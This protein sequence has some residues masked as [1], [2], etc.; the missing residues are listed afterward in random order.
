MTDVFIKEKKKFKPL[1]CGFHSHAEFSLDG[2]STSKDKIIYADSLGMAADTLT[3]HGV[4]SGLYSQWAAANKLK[5]SGK[6]SS[7]FK[8]IQGVEAYVIDHDRPMKPLRKGSD[9]MVHQYYHLTIHFK[10]MNAY[11]YFCQ[12]SRKAEERAI[13]KYGERKP[14]IEFTELEPICKE[15][16]IGSGCLSSPVQKNILQGR[17]ELARKHYEYLRSLVGPSNFYVEVFPHITDHE[18]KKPVFDKATKKIV[19]PGY[20]EPITAPRDWEGK[21]EDVWQPDPCTGCLDIQKV[22]NKAVLEFAAKYGDKPVVSLDD[23]YG[24]PKD[25]TVQELRL[26]NGTENWKFYNS[27]HVMS[28]EEAAVNFK[29]QLGASDKEIES[30][31]DNGYE[32]IEHFNN[33][34]FPDR[35]D[36]I[37][38]PTTEMVYDVRAA[39]KSSRE[40]FWELVEKHGKMP[41]EGDPRYKTYRERVEFELSVLIDN[42]AGIDF[43]P[44]V[45]LLEDL[46]EYARNNTILYTS[47]GCLTG[48]TLVK[49]EKCYKKLSDIVVGDNV[50][51]HTGE[52][53]PVTHTMSYPLYNKKLTEIKTEFAFGSVKMTPEHKVWGVKRKLKNTYKKPNGGIQRYWCDFSEK[54]LEWVAAKDL[55]VGDLIYTPFVDRKTE[56]FGEKIDLASYVKS[57]EY[58]KYQICEKYIDVKIPLNNDLSLRNIE[59]NTGVRR[60]VL[61]KLKKRQNVSTNITAFLNFLKLRNLTLEDWISN[62]NTRTVRIERFIPKNEEFWYLIGKWI[63][64]GWISDNQKSVTGYAFHSEE[65]VEIQKTKDFFEKYCIYVSFR[66]AKNRKLTQLEL[67]GI[68]LCRVLREMFPDYKN[69]S[70]TKYIGQY[71]NLKDEYL[72]ALIL[73]L[74]SADGSVC[75][76]R[77][78]IDTTSVRLAKEIKEC[79]LYLKIPSSILASEPRMSGKYLCRK[80]YKVAFCGLS[81]EYK[82]PKKMIQENGYFS[83]V[84]SINS[85]EDYDTVY[86]ITVEKNHSYL[87]SNF[88]VH[89]SAGGSL[90]LFL[91]GIIITDPI[92]HK[93]SFERFLNPGRI[94]GGSWPDVDLDWENRHLIIDYIRKKYGD[95]FALI[96]NDSKMKLKTSILDATRAV[97]GHVPN[98]IAFLSKRISIPIGEDDARWLYGDDGE[99]GFWNSDDPLAKELRAFADA[100]EE[101]WNMVNRCMGITR[102]RGIHAGGIVI[103]PKPVHECMPVIKAKDSEDY[104]TAYDMIGVEET[105]G[106]KFDILGIKTLDAL[107]VAMRSIE[108]TTGEKMV[109]GE[110]PE[111]PEVFENVIK[112]MKLEGVFQLNT[113]VAR[114]YV[115]KTQPKNIKEISALT[116]LCRPGALDAPCPDPSVNMTAA[117]YYVEVAQGRR[118]PYF[119]HEDL[120]PIL[121]ETHS[122]IL[123]QEQSMK[124]GTLAG[125]SEADADTIIRKGIGKKKKDKIEQFS[126]DLKRELPKRGWSDEQIEQLINAVMASARYQFN[127]AHSASYAIVAWNCAYIKHYYPAHYWKG[128]LTTFDGD[129][130]KLKGLLEEC[131]P[132]IRPLSIKHSHP[133]DWTIEDETFLRPPI[134]IVKGCGEKGADALRAIVDQFKPSSWDEF[135][136]A[137][138]EAKKEKTHK[139]DVAAI[140]KLLYVGALDEFITDA[141]TLKTYEEYRKDLVKSIKSTAKLTKAKKNE[142]IGLIDLKNDLHLNLWRFQSNPLHH[143][144]FVKYFENALKNMGFVLTGNKNMI[145]EKIDNGDRHQ[146]WASYEA[147][148][149]PQLQRLLRVKPKEAHFHFYFLGQTQ[150]VEHVTNKGKRRLNFQIF[151]GEDTTSRITFWPPW[152]QDDIPPHVLASLQNDSIG[153]IKVTGN[154]FQGNLYLNAL[155]WAE[156]RA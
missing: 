116:A 128:M 2:G 104:A 95:K 94:K 64:D 25:R 124:I 8:V 38:L 86:D 77:E 56:C 66:N 81:L 29:K 52:I 57:T 44:Y 21:P 79:L 31:I 98:E 24:N 129:S 113:N 12:L 107:G 22:C 73:G 105:G 75:D 85:N 140:T 51:T 91:L 11:F 23:H 118:E 100:H 139:I 117:E 60:S 45:F 5:D 89:N 156:L 59:R 143:F 101:I 96:A 71:K 20:F 87:T 43:M 39:Q 145:A 97:L 149:K 35:D 150:K 69:T 18:W 93:L 137:L 109:W 103:A 72:K 46:C 138:I 80:N 90:A 125:Y 16:T 65:L 132:H 151:T 28:S 6:I 26:G 88:A 136:N 83:A 147:L 112:E 68:L 14:L 33:Y 92:K 42:D 27:Y 141:K 108:K 70:R 7:S 102:Q 148:Q 154:L 114:P 127:K 17:P 30:W 4:M 40:L 126:N 120:R 146:I 111:D 123:Y 53:K 133:S 155:E 115:K 135:K 106:V 131:K 144:S 74:Q 84:R 47:R 36:Q 142:S 121:E 41:K 55:S 10:T 110:F 32:F 61:K 34:K 58:S 19:E 49:T 9:V 76:R 13:L 3:D 54:D 134:N 78:S 15:I 130:D 62:D 37:L 99:S 119:I 153:L 122:I 48:D 67:G 82:N 63:G 152:G 50:Y 1:A